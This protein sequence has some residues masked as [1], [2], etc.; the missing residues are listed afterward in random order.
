MPSIAILLIA[1][2]LSTPSLLEAWRHD[3]YSRG[4]PAAFGIWLSALAGFRFLPRSN[5]RRHPVI[6]TVLAASCCAAGSMTDLRVVCHFGLACALTGIAGFGISG[7]MALA[8]GLAW[9]PATG[10]FLSGAFT[11]GLV[12]WERPAAVLAGSFV[13]MITAACRKPRHL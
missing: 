1:A 13:C 7:V 2:Y 3:G 10:W 12:G 5:G 8:L 11:G 9:M 4:G 6:W